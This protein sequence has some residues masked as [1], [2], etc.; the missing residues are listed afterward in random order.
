[1]PGRVDN[2]DRYDFW[3]A[4]QSSLGLSAQ[5]DAAFLGDEEGASGYSLGLLASYAYH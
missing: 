2:R 4:A 1:M 5:F 3:I